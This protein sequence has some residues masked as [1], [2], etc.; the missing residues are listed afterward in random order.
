MDAPLDVTNAM[1]VHVV[2][3][4]RSIATILHVFPRVNRYNLARRHQSVDP[5]HQHRVRREIP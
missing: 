5:M 2:L 4:L 3:S 1:E